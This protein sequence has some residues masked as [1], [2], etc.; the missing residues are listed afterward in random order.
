LNYQIRN[1]KN[2]KKVGIDNQ[3]Q[4]GCQSQNQDSKLITPNGEA[5]GLQDFEG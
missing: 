1:L 3:Y 2:I 5:A 4:K